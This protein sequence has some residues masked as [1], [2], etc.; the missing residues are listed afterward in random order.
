MEA[1]ETLIK[2]ATEAA[3]QKTGFQI[4]PLY[5]VL[6]LAIPLLLGIPLAWITKLIEKG[7]TRLLGERR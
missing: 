2:M 7:L 6:N 5:V 4:Q 3:P 1:L